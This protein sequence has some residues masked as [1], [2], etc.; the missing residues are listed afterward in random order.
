MVGS[1]PRP[2]R[3]SLKTCVLMP[4]MTAS[5]NTLMPADTTFPKTFSARN[6][7]LFQSA[8]GTSTNPASVVSLN[9]ISVIKS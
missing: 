1:G 4:M 8:N 6:D 3:K 9:S 2:V 5:T 7:V